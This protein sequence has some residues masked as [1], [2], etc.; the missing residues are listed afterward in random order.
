MT[1][2]LLDLGASI[3]ILQ[4]SLYDQYDSGPLRAAATTIVLAAQTSKLPLEILTDFIVKVEDFYFLFDFLV[5]D[6]VLGERIEHL[7]VILSRPFSATANANI[8]CTNGTV[9]M[10]FG[11]RE[12]RI[13]VFTNVNNSL[14]DDGCFMADVIDE[15]IPLYNSVVSTDGTTEKCF[16]F[17]RLHMETDK[18]LEEEE[19]QLG[20]GIV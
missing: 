8:D 2:A 18:L 4:G 10:A 14:V 19:R 16:L 1:R 13:N 6:Y 9:D 12:L 3:G 17:D 5:I 15:C 20:V 11:N 7:T